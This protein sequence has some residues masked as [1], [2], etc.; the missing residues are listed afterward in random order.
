MRVGR[1][2]YRVRSQCIE[3]HAGEYPCSRGSPWTPRPLRLTGMNRKVGQE[4]IC[5]CG[6]SACRVLRQVNPGYLAGRSGAPRRWFMVFQE[7]AFLNSS[8]SCVSE[9]G[10]W[11]G[12]SLLGQNIMLHRYFR[13]GDWEGRL[14][15]WSLRLLT[16]FSVQLY[17]IYFS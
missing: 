12:R 2:G 10:I 9:A 8:L 13:D 1:G 15:S 11:G 6:L 5:L 3:Q 14:C 16:S 17:R 7:S 4:G